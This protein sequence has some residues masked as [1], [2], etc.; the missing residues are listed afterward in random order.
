MYEAK[1]FSSIRE[2]DGFSERMM[3]EH[4]KLYEGYV[5]KANEIMDKLKSVDKESANQVYSD[6]RGLKLE[7]PFAVG[8][9]KNHEIYFEHLGG[10]GGKP[11]GLMDELIAK[12]F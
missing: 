9:I 4:Y 5:K 8:G 12:N 7:L 3:T 2:M 1:K 10:K 6:L 11:N